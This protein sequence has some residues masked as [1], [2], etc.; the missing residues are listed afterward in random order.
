MLCPACKKLSIKKKNR[1]NNVRRMIREK[2][3]PRY[4]NDCGIKLYNKR[5]GLC[6]ECKKNH[7][8]E[9]VRK[10][11]ASEGRRRRRTFRA[12]EMGYTCLNTP[13]VGS[14]G[15]HIDQQYVIYIPKDLH[16]SI[17]HNH[18]DSSTM[19]LINYYAIEYLFSKFLYNFSWGTP[20]I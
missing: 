19:E 12:R 7:V 16:K 18:Q 1:K 20:Y 5:N 8:K 14:E 17:V 2:L 11:N 10:H 4:C 6:N 13:F 3:R 9:T 15:H